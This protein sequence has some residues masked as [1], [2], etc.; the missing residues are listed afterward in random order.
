M[1]AESCLATCTDNGYSIAQVEQTCSDTNHEADVIAC[2]CQ[3]GPA[4]YEEMISWQVF[5]GDSPNEAFVSGTDEGSGYMGCFIPE[6]AEDA[7]TNTPSCG[8][9]SDGKWVPTDAYADYGSGETQ[10]DDMLAADCVSN[11]SALSYELASVE[12][13]DYI[14]S[15]FYDDWNGYYGR[16]GLDDLDDKLNVYDEHKVG[17]WCQH[18]PTNGTYTE[19]AA[20]A[21]RDDDDLNGW[22]GWDGNLYVACLTPFHSVYEAPAGSD[23]DDEGLSVTT[24][25]IVI[26]APLVAIGGGVA[27]FF[28]HSGS[29]QVAKTATEMA[30]L[31]V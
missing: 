31:P 25:A 6:N 3:H 9:A 29:G 7:R 20:Q 21:A 28:M 12:D 15:S 13:P 14:W 22:N 24:L 8:S 2:Y 4:S 18:F 16:D 19:L 30:T 10:L 11:C 5:I 1:T 27:F 26:A 23:G 17:C